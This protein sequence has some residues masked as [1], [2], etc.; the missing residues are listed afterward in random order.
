M[1][2]FWTRGNAVFAFT[3]SVLATMTFAAF[4][5]TSF[6][7]NRT[8]VRISSRNAQVKNI[9]NYSANRA[10]NDLASL[11]LDV[12]MDMSSIFN[13]NVKQLFIFLVAE[14]STPTNEVNQVVLWDKIVM[15][16]ENPVI[17]I[18]S[19]PPKYYF[20]DDGNGLL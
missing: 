3:L 15:R 19:I 9:P 16:G 4:L 7:D 10:K 5:S 17:D 18:S 14:Y 20:W 11:S 12:E 6:N 2:T 1:H 8:S 13:W